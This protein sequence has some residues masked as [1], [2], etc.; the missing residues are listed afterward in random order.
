MTFIPMHFLGFLGMP[1]RIYTYAPDRGWESMNM[2]ATIGVAF[3]M[4]GI[5]CFV[6]N[7]ISSLIRGPRA[8][9]DPWDAWTLEWTT[10]SPPPEYNFEKIPVVHS[11]RPLWDLKHPGDPDW[12][13]E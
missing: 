7:V 12:R 10:S 13:F 6:W 1:R 9:D 11:S 5:L 3:Q 8:G 2:L 4:A